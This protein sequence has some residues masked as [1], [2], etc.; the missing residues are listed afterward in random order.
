MLKRSSSTSLERV[1]DDHMVFGRVMNR[2]E[3]MAISQMC[4]GLPV[5]TAILQCALCV[6][7]DPH[8][9]IL[10]MLDVITLWVPCCVTRPLVGARNQGGVCCG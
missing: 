6:G 9:F 1:A 4:L 8:M 2:W 10:H 3:L 7:F 5:F